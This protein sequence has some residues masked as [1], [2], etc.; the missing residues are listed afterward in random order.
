MCS[1]CTF[2]Q[3]TGLQKDTKIRRQQKYPQIL[4]SVNFVVGEESQF[5]LGRSQNFEKRLLASSCQ[6]ARE[7]LRSH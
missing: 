2:R 6:P 5:F 3:E 1:P 7:K 4:L